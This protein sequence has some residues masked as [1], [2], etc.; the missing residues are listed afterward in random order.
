MD[1][2]EFIE[3]DYETIGVMELRHLHDLSKLNRCLT[4]ED[5][6]KIVGVYNLVVDRIMSKQSSDKKD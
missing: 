6:L 5:F 2:E 3:I 4:N 1:K